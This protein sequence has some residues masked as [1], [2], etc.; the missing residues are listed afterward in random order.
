MKSF[1]RKALLDIKDQP[2]PQMRDKSEVKKKDEVAEWNINQMELLLKHHDTQLNKMA[3]ADNKSERF[4]RRYNFR[5]IG[6]K[7]NQ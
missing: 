2:M 6:I 5:I 4:S 7:K 1:V 3:D